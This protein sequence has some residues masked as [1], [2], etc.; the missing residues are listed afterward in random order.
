MTWDIFWQKRIGA[1]GQAEVYLAQRRGREDT[2][3]EFYRACK[4]GEASALRREAL[5]LRQL[6]HPCFPYFED[7]WEQGDTGFLIMEYIHG[8]TMEACMEVKPISMKQLE[9]WSGQLAE[10]LLALHHMP[11]PWL[12]RDLKP[13]NIMVR[14]DGRVKLVDLGCA[15]PLTEAGRSMAGTPGYGAPEQFRAPEQVTEASDLYGFGKLLEQLLDACHVR[16][17]RERI[18]YRRYKRFCKSCL[19]EEIYM[20][21]GSVEQFLAN[22]QKR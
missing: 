11:V 12:Y 22:V 3:D 20:R 19:K 16:G 7:Y 21:P 1:G 13:S 4:V 2:N 17:W 6:R 9:Y 5:L 8:R 18:R 14:E 15:C 10:A